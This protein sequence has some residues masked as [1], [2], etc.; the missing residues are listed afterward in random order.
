MTCFDMLNGDGPAENL[1]AEIADAAARC[2]FWRKKAEDPM[3]Y[4]INFRWEK[5][6][7]HDRCCTKPDRLAFT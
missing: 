1:Y 2:K 7:V 4:R 5:R 6:L 3:Q